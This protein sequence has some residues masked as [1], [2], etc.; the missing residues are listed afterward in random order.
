MEDTFLLSTA[1]EKYIDVHSLPVI[2]VVY[3]THPWYLAKSEKNLFFIT[4]QSQFEKHKIYTF[5][6]TERPEHT[7][8]TKAQINLR[9]Q[10]AWSG[11]FTYRVKK[12]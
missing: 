3:C 10:A 2:Q 1:D 5:S 7:W 9:Y 6:R 4:D 11:A 12:D 8:A